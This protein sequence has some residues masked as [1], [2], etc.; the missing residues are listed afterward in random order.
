MVSGLAA[1]RPRRFISCTMK[2]TGWCGTGLLILRAQPIA[3]MQSG[4]SFTHVL[5]FSENT[6]P[7]SVSRIVSSWL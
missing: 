2:I 5:I 1:P 7:R 4:R 6:R 3:L